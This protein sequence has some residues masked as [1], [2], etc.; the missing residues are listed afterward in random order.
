MRCDFSPA[1]AGD[2]TEIWAYL[3]RYSIDSA[4][5]I[6]AEIEAVCGRIAEQPGI[7]HVRNDLADQAL[8]VWS[9]R[10]YLIIYRP[11]TVAIEIVRI[12][13]GYRD[14]EQLELPVDWRAEGDL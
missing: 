13:S 1:A 6:V 8:R 3:T 11:T 14:L 4:D 12:V 2:L 5:R 10:T 9:V 7:G